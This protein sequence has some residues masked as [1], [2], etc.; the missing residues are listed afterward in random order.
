MQDYSE[1]LSSASGASSYCRGSMPSHWGGHT[2]R[3]S[4]PDPVRQ[5][6]SARARPTTRVRYPIGRGSPN[7]GKRRCRPAESLG[8]RPLPNTAESAS[9][10][11]HHSPRTG[12]AQ[13][14]APRIHSARHGQCQCHGQSQTRR[15][16]TDHSSI[17]ASRSYCHVVAIRSRC[18]APP[19]LGSPLS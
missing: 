19:R 18:L 12:S 7:S 6:Q 17:C 1:L 5:I 14:R 11:C 13:V 2:V 15:N 8:S 16:L 9:G 4:S 10:T 3:S